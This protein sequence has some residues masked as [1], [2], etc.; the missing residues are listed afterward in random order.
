M[1]V[2]LIDVHLIDVPLIGVPHGMSLFKQRV[3]FRSMAFSLRQW[4][5]GSVLS[6]LGN[7][8]DRH[9]T[10]RKLLHYAGRFVSSLGDL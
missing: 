1:D 3:H 7:T 8:V 2:P 6:D 9:R 5:R 10:G 4:I